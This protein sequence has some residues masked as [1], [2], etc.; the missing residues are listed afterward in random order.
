[1]SRITP[2]K[3]H[4]I[5]R[6]QAQELLSSL[7]EQIGDAAEMFSAERMEILETDAAI[8]LYLVDRKPLLMRLQGMVFPTLRGLLEHPFPSRRVV[9][10]SG[11]VP[12]VIKGADVMRPGITSISDDVTAGM[13]VQVV[14]ER[15]GKPIALGIALFDACEMREK[16]TGKVIKTLYYVGDDLWSLEI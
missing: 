15:H 1:M 7:R 2:R 6:S 4:T 11:A 8:S 16:N 14:E 9:V 13:P 5:R 3:R 12:F 10:D